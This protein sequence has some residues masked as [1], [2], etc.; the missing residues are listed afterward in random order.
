MSA[1]PHGPGWWQASDGRFYPPHTH[2]SY[3]QP[4]PRVQQHAAPQLPGYVPPQVPQRPSSGGVPKGLLIAGGAVLLVIVLG[5][6]ATSFVFDKIGEGLVGDSGGDCTL[7]AKQDVDRVLGGDF[8]LIELG[9]LSEIAS[10][11][12]DARVLPDGRTCWATRNGP[13]AAQLVRIARLEA[14]D[15]SQRFQLERAAAQGVQEDRGGGITVESEPYFNKDVDF[16]DE[17][18]CTTTDFAGSSGML[19]RRGGVLVYVS[20]TS[21]RFNPQ[22]DPSAVE[23]GTIK[24]EDDDAHCT[25]A[26]QLAEAVR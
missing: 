21:A 26:A 11:A 16:G 6:V 25:V 2:P 19:V 24:F 18:F 10:P 13:D 20:L 5:F 9:G 22:I 1:T 17:A 15:A 7:I 12:M 23:N 14:A 4:Q 3:R 8:E